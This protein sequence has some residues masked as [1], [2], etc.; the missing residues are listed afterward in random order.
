MEL[1][2]N[3]VSKSSIIDISHGLNVIHK[4]IGKKEGDK[5]LEQ[6]TQLRDETTPVTEVMQRTLTIILEQIKPFIHMQ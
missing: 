5:I 4:Y 3:G 1:T 6:L 2:Q